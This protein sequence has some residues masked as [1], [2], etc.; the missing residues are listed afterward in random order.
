MHDSDIQ[1]LIGRIFNYSRK[2]GMSGY[3]PRK[4]L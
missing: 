3:P 1:P 2:F 4:F